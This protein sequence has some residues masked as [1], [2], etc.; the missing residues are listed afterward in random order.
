[1]DGKDVPQ[2][3]NSEWTHV[4]DDFNYWIEQQKGRLKPR[5]GSL[6]SVSITSGHSAFMALFPTFEDAYKA[7]VTQREQDFKI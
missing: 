6:Q 5:F 4:L 2:Y 7:Y 1:M 3:V